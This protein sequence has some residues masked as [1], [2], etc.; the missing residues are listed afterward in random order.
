[1]ATGAAEGIIL[2]LY[3]GCLSGCNNNI[4]RRP[5]HRNCQCAL[6]DKSHGNCPHAFAK[7]KSISYPLRRAW[8]EGCLAVSA[9]SSPCS[10]P[11]WSSRVHGAAG[12]HHM[13]SYKEEEEDNNNQLESTSKV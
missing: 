1:M 11:A 7:S 8:S 13:E 10:S 4:E 9:A 3:E 2:S 5:Y 12:P 6:H